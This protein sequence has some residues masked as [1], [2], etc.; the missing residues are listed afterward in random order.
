MYPAMLNIRAVYL[1]SPSVVTRLLFSIYKPVSDSYVNV[2]LPGNI[3]GGGG[4]GNTH[5]CVGILSVS[6]S[7]Y[8]WL[9]WW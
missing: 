2:I 3:G 7:I 4:E 9:C 1:N 8:L 6:V 5:G